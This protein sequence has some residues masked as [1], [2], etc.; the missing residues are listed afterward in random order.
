MVN[1]QGHASQP[2]PRNSASIGTS[3]S[4]KSAL[5]VLLVIELLTEDPAGLTFAQI[6]RRLDLPKSSAY[7]LLRTMTEAGHLTLDDGTHLYR[8]G[9][10]IWQAGEAY[11]QGF[12]LASTA[13]PH[14]RAARDQ[15]GET[16]QLAVLDGMYNVYLAK[17]EADQRLVLQSRVGGRLPAYATG[18]GK[19][20]LAG[21]A[22]EELSARL[23]GEELRTFT[24]TTIIDPARLLAVL[25]EIRERG[26]GTDHGEFTDGVV[27]VAVP[28]RGRHGEVVAAMSVSVPSVRAQANFEPSAAEVLG[29]E[30]VA[31][32]RLL[33]YQQSPKS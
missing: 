11:L 31:L 4:V 25:H 29:R 17:E 28:V 22:D 10:R 26:Y 6:C 12:D 21:L 15:L 19:V 32:S 20:L 5:R 24:S 23:A 13:R 33:G 18:L 9:I 16:V 7:A 14:L 27:C 2:R 3:E 8:L 1:P 30:A